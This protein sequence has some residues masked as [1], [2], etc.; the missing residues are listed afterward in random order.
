MV[1]ISNVADEQ[2]LFR[3]MDIFDFESNCVEDEKI[4]DTRSTTRIG[5]YDP[6]SIS[7]SCNDLED[8]IFLCEVNLVTWCKFSM[9]L[10]KTLPH[11]LKPN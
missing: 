2:K 11:S 5:K 8:P 4:K 7:K 6:V 10:W 9:M 3:N 1:L